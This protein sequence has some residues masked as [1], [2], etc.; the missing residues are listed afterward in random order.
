MDVP[1]K[2]ERLREIYHRLASSPAASTASE[3]LRQLADIINAVEDAWTEIPFDPAS[4]R[5]DGRIYPPQADNEREVEGRPTLRRYR[6]LK[7]NTYIGGNGA[8]EIQR[9]DGTVEFSKPGADGR[10]VWDL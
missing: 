8:I 5:H 10:G 6:S 7:H 1:P 2:S 4:W 9:L 3:A